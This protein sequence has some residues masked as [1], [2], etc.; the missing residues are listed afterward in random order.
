MEVIRRALTIRYA[1]DVVDIGASTDLV[2]ALPEIMDRALSG[3]SCP[4]QTHAESLAAFARAIYALQL[5]GGRCA[6]P[7]SPSGCGLYD[8]QNRYFDPPVSTVGYSEASQGYAG[9]IPSSFGVDLVDVI[10]DPSLNGQPL[11]IEFHSDSG[12]AAAFIVQVWE[13]RSLGEGT[14]PRALATGV[15]GPHTLASEG[16]DGELS[17]VIAAADRTGPNVLGLIITRIDED[18]RVDREGAYT[19]VVHPADPGEMATAERQP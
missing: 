11:E 12:S 5:D 14:N 17:T 9:Q 13:V 3:S 1:G 19:V 18:E 15:A 16:P 6:S 4:F 8:P 10:L 7:R 2:G